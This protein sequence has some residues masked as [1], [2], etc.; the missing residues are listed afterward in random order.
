MEALADLT[1]DERLLC[2][3]CHLQ[4]RASGK[5]MTWCRGCKSEWQRGYRAGIKLQRRIPDPVRTEGGCL[6]FQGRVNPQTGY[7]QVQG[8]NQT[9]LYAH[10]LAWENAHGPIPNGM[11]IDHLCEVKLCIEPTHLEPCSRGDNVR[12]YHERRRGA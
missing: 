1:E 10:R 9:T 4:P 11:T 12:R 6:I 8:P 2:N 7:G 3:R 5:R